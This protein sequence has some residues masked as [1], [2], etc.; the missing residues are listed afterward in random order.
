MRRGQA[1]QA[2]ERRRH[3][4]RGGDAAR[5]GDP[6]AQRPPGQEFH[7][8]QAE[9]V[10]FDVVVHG[11]DMRVVERGQ[12]LGLRREPAARGRVAR[13]GGGQLLDGDPAAELAVLAGDHHSH[14][15]L[16]QLVADVVGGQRVAQVLQV[17]AHGAVRPFCWR[18]QSP[19][20]SC[21]TDN[22]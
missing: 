16:A 2:G 21:N 7:D 14:A 17:K 11:H 5:V 8:E 13:E 6:A 9:A 15:P 10:A 22:S 18:G 3:R 1:A 19:V 4:V 20:I 12:D